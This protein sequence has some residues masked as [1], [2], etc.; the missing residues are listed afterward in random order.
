MRFSDTDWLDAISRTG[1]SQSYDLSLSNA[2][3]KYSALMS[4]GYKKNTGI[5]KYTD[6][7]NFS[8]PCQHQLQREQACHHW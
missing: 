5:L 7:E 6:F 4:L 8:G 3:D 2:T 1:F